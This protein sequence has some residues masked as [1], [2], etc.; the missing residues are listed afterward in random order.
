[1]KQIIRYVA[2]WL[3]FLLSL[4]APVVLNK[5]FGAFISAIY[6]SSIE[7]QFFH[8]GKDTVIAYKPLNLRGLNCISIGNNTK[9]G[10]SVQ[11]TAWES[12]G[13][14]KYNPRISI[15]DNCIIREGAHISAINNVQ[16]GN[17]LL[18]GNNVYI[19]DNSHG[20]TDDIQL[21]QIH[22]S[23]RPIISKGP[24]KIGNNVWLGNNVC[25]LSGVHIGDGSIIGSNSV[26]T[27]D[28]PSFSVAAGVPA[29]IIKHFSN[30]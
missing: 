12:Y 24:V 27:H 4:L 22:P 8:F 7:C 3:G 25:V 9:I 23:H 19:S 2:K 18:T 15:G 6:T 21:L 14:Q 11:L 29:R 26:V 1:M 5:K 30:N 17:N 28:I 13:N 10:K 20:G 16:I